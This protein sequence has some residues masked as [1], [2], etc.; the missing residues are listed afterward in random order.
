MSQDAQPGHLLGPYSC[1]STRVQLFIIG[2]GIV[3]HDAVFRP[4]LETGKW[5]KSAK[6]PHFTKS[7][8]EPEF[9]LIFLFMLAGLFHIALG[10]PET[11]PALLQQQAIQQ[12]EQFVEHFRQTGDRKTEELQQADSKLAKSY[13][14]FIGIYDLAS[15]ALSLIKRGDIQRMQDHWK[16]ALDLYKTAEEKA[17]RA[18]HLTYQ[19]QALVGQAKAAFDGRDY[20]AAAA[21]IEQAVQLSTRSGDTRTRF[22]A[23]VQM[24]HIQS[25]RGDLN[26]AADTITRALSP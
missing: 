1:L 16:E 15:A 14:A 13:D 25:S 23:L 3:S 22:D 8:Q 12:I 9:G 6:R 21:A 5:Y 26:A 17:Q 4:L 7:G 11:D 24:S 10:N 18:N 19:A 2:E 20:G